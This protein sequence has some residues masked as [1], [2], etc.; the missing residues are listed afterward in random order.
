VERSKVTA[1]EWRIRPLASADFPAIIAIQNESRE[2]AQW[3]ATDYGSALRSGWHCVLVEEE[4][5]AG[6]LIARAQLGELEILNMAVLPGQRVRGAGSLLLREALEFGR[7]RGAKAAFVEVRESNGAVAFY[8]QHGFT[9]AGRRKHYY[10]NPA[11]DALLL[12]RPL[13]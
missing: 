6:F 12:S 11:E 5:V 13:T 9:V 8:L 7:R 3:S 1:P 4:C 10:S 2:A